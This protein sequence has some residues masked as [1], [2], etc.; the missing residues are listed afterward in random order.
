MWVTHHAAARS[1]LYDTAD[2]SAP[3][4][5]VAAPLGAGVLDVAT[6]AEGAAEPGGLTALA[7]ALA[8]TPG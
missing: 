7:L 2:L 1:T 4:L 6:E 3:A 5:V 8:G